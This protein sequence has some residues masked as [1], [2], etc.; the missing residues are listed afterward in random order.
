MVLTS[1]ESTHELCTYN[2]KLS[3]L[4]LGGHKG[5]RSIPLL[6]LLTHDT[7]TLFIWSDT[8]NCQ[9]DALASRFL[10]VFNCYP[11]QF[12]R[13][14][15]LNEVLKC[16]ERNF[17]VLFLFIFLIVKKK[18]NGMLMTFKLSKR[19]KNSLLDSYTYTYSRF[20]YLYKN[21]KS[22]QTNE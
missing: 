19:K 17:S 2:T 6:W 11:R 5:K 21:L 14:K 4:P 1:W 13:M 20:F 22:V 18:I 10:F 16:V 7:A 8:F 12:L 15:S 3:N 9:C